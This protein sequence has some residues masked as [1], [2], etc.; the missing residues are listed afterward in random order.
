M[1]VEKR[2]GDGERNRERER[3]RNSA[4]EK[5]WRRKH[6]AKEREQFVFVAHHTADSNKMARL[7]S[8]CSSDSSTAIFCATQT[9]TNSKEFISCT[10]DKTKRTAEEF[11]CYTHTYTER[12]KK[13][14]IFS[15]QHRM[16]TDII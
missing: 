2:D 11:V 1:N 3:E 15:H 12:W 5:K 16:K 8:P 4:R 9:Q 14:L 13:V 10:G 7:F 6:E